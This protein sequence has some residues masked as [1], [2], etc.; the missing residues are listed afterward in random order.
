VAGSHRVTEISWEAP[1][2]TLRLRR[3]ARGV[4]VLIISGTDV[5]EHGVEPFTELE[6]ELAAGAFDLFV[7]ARAS[8]GVTIDVS[9]EWSR[10]LGKNKGALRSIHMLTASRFVQLTANFV[11]N[12]AALGE[13]M[14]IYTEPAAFEAEL[15]AALARGRAEPSAI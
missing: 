9:S 7:D 6:K 8:R 14:R 2:S 3:P 11:R 5:G 1:H 12:F 13:L 15:E 10:W 4:V